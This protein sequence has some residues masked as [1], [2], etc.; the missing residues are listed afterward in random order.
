MDQG[1]NRIPVFDVED[2][3]SVPEDL[4]GIGLPQCP[5]VAASE[6]GQSTFPAA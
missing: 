1:V 3:S 6:P 5:I 4:G 2:V